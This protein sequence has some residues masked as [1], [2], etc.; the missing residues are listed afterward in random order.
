MIVLLRILIVL[1]GIAMYVKGETYT[2][3]LGQS[4]KIFKTLMGIP[5]GLLWLLSGH[6][7]AALIV[8]GAYAIA[9]QVSYGDNNWL[10]KLVGKRLAITITGFCLGLASWPFLGLLALLQALLAAIVWYGVSILDD[11]NIVKE[12]YV[13][14]LRSIGGLCLIPL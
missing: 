10:T 5:M 4:N 1:V 7:L 2:K 11:A 12:P 14:I 9:T 3:L 13:A 6:W 8:M